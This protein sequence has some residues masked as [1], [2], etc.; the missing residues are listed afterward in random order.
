MF[1]GFDPESGTYD[2]ASW[3][4]AGTEQGTT[5]GREERSSQSF[6]EMTGAGMDG[7]VQRDETLQH[8]RCVLQIL[9]RHFARYT[10][11]M[12]QEVC[13][14]E[15]A[16]LLRVADTLIANSGRE[17]TT[18]LAYAVGWTQHSS[19]VQIIRAASILQLLLGNVGRPGG[20]LLAERGHASIQGSTDVPRSTTSSRATCTCPRR[21]R[22]RSRWPSTSTPAAATPAGGGRTSTGTR[23]RYSRPGSG[24]RRRRRTTSASAT[25]RRSTA[26]TRTSRR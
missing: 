4:Y 5:P 24:R 14:I 21:G 3:R 25:C 17:R 26:T 8:P 10:P 18:A 9:R 2:P 7:E 6:A 22:S 16:L 19:G 23:S 12:V 13:G 15:P 20:G 1:S 11:E